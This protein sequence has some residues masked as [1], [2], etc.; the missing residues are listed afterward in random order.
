MESATVD[1]DKLQSGMFAQGDYVSFPLSR[2]Y[3]ALNG[4]LELSGNGLYVENENVVYYVTW[5]NGVVD[6]DVIVFDVRSKSLRGHYDVRH[7][8]I[9][10]SRLLPTKQSS[11]FLYD[12]NIRW[13]GSITSQKERYGWGLFYDADGKLCYEGFCIGNMYLGYGRF[14]HVLSST[15]EYEGTICNNMRCGYGSLYNEEGDLLYQGSFI[16]DK[17]LE[18]ICLPVSIGGSAL[19]KLANRVTSVAIGDSCMNSFR[20]IIDFSILP[21]LSEL[22]IGNG[23][24]RSCSGF[25]VRGHEF[26]SLIQ[27]GKSSF[28]YKEDK[29]KKNAEPISFIIDHC[30]L[31]HSVH[32][33][34]SAFPHYSVCTIQC[35]AFLWLLTVSLSIPNE[36]G[37]QTLRVP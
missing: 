3:Y 29:R 33:Q 34:D 9:K 35:N 19:S 27:I 18:W 11:L 1:S 7:G 30:P 24:F 16:N 15:V 8:F 12:H 23:S 36:R 4:D 32:V 31:L 21:F 22:R 2:C 26:L 6:G 13:E 28:T 20:G 17:P 14:Y 5:K 37:A 25:C 10:H